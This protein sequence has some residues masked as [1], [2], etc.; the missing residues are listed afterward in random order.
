MS[1]YCA[2][3]LVSASDLC[4]YRCLALYG[5]KYVG[6]EVLECKH[7]RRYVVEQQCRLQYTST[8]LVS[9]QLLFTIALLKPKTITYS[10]STFT[11][12]ANVPLAAAANVALYVSIIT[13]VYLPSSQVDDSHPSS[14]S[15]SLPMNVQGPIL[16]TVRTQ[17]P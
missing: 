1:I 17:V 14:H 3:F 12:L 16:V 2:M 9:R 7:I 4:L 13:I 11:V 15:H 10:H 8:T 6:C 5:M